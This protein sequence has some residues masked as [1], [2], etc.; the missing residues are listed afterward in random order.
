MWAQF[1]EQDKTAISL[2]RRALILNPASAV[3]HYYYGLELRREGTEEEAVAE[4]Q[5]AKALAGDKGPIANS[6]N[7]EVRPKY[8]SFTHDA[9]GNWVEVTGK[10]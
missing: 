10:K 6:V 5:K 9:K 8:R 1:H 2:Y 7:I 4:L 3:A